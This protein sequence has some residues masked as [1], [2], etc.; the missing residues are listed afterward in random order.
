MKR[1][2]WP[3]THSVVVDRCGKCRSIWFDLGDVAQIRTYN[4]FETIV[5]ISSTNPPPIVPGTSK[6]T[7]ETIT[8]PSEADRGLMG[9]GHFH[10]FHYLGLPTEEEGT[11]KRIVPMMTIVLILFWFALSIAY[12]KSPN[13]WIKWAFM[14]GDPFANRGLNWIV[15]LFLHG[16]W[17]HLLSNAYFFWICGDDIEDEIGPLHLFGLFVVGG[18]AGH[19]AAMALGSR[20]PNIGASA[21]ITAALMYYALAFSKHRLHLTRFFE[22]YKPTWESPIFQRASISYSLSAGFFVI[23][24]LLKELLVV[25]LNHG[26]QP[27]AYVHYAANLAGLVVGLVFYIGF[28]RLKR[29]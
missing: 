27:A 16:G 19:L 20:L 29:V 14:P 3:A 15:S 25:G 1:I 10:P 21:G 9:E 17:F 26:G 7:N 2:Y 18:A 23:F 22:Y 12:F 4:Q 5:P 28:P 6:L 13:H 8:M 24:F 11:S